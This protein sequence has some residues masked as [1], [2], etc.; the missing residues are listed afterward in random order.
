MPGRKLRHRRVM[1]ATGPWPDRRQGRQWG[2][3]PWWV[4]LSWKRSARTQRVSAR[5]WRGVRCP[6]NLSRQ[7]READLGDVEHADTHRPAGRHPKGALPGASGHGRYDAGTV[8]EPKWVAVQPG[9]G[10][11]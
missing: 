6:S 11:V 4:L 3:C 2:R 9:R 1:A 7:R 8:T 5:R 10:R